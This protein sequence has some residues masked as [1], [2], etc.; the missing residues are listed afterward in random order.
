MTVGILGGGISGL[1]FAYFLQH[2][3][4]ISDYEILEKSISC[5]GLCTTFEKNGFLYDIGGHIIFSS[6]KD[7]LKFEIDL[8][9]DKGH[10]R[11][12]S[13]KIWY[14]NR[15]VKYP[16]E[17]GLS[18]L[19]KEEIF[20]CLRDYLQ[21]NHPK[22]TNLKEWFYY[23]FGTSLAEKYLLPYNEKIWKIDPAFMG[24]EWVERIPKPPVE[25]VIKS[26]IG[27]E[28]EGYT[29]QL[30]FYYPKKGGFQTLIRT[31]EEKIQNIKTDKEVKSIYKE[32][33]SWKVQTNDSLHTYD[34]LISTLSLHDLIKLL[35]NKLPPDINQAITDLRYNS[36]AVVMVGLNKVKHED[37]TAVYVP[38]KDSLAH[39]YCFSA[40][41]SEHLSPP[42]CSSIFAE[43]TYHPDS[44]LAKAK[45]EEFIDK[46][47]W[48]LQKEG[49]I[50][51][52]EVCETDIK[53]LK[54]AYPVY[55]L[56]YTKNI[57]KIYSYFD[58]LGIHLLGRFAQFIYINS[59]VCIANAKNLAEKIKVTMPI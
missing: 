42:G 58:T 43:I 55:D 7:I 1:S 40:G 33:K 18:V 21:N 45:D 26:A 27:I 10:K 47:V 31:F 56:N 19:D 49:F 30:Y 6:N 11:R 51:K 41:F 57:N 16:F 14:K 46:T 44:D 52:S 24:M 32:G 29:H 2:E 35:K 38:D 25:D 37:L 12:R 9:G 53:R 54:Y 34:Q 20:E 23:T 13:N 36:M 28:T 15:F 17:N 3:H 4:G 22:P 50:E 39:R 8:L 48:W 5:G 59:D